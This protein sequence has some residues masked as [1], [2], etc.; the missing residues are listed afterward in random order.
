MNAEQI[1]RTL[2]ANSREGKTPVVVWGR[3]CD[4]AEATS[5][6]TIDSNLDA[7]IK[8]YRSVENSAEGAFSVTI[9]SPEE[10]DEF[11]PTFRD[12]AAEQA[13]Y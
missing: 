6:H 5:L 9:I 8:L 12:R 11:H 2:A 3:D 7:Y 4:N 1:M 10:A 13:G